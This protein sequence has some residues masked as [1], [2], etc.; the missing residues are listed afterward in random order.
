MLGLWRAEEILEMPQAELIAG[1]R[2]AGELQLPLA[3]SDSRAEGVGCICVV[4]SGSC[5]R[6]PPLWPPGRLAHLLCLPVCGLSGRHS[7][8]CFYPDTNSREALTLP[9]LCLSVTSCCQHPQQVHKG[10][11]SVFEC[12]QNQPS[13]FCP[14]H[15][16]RHLNIKF[17]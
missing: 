8:V 7:S 4:A 13:P 16:P 11:P 9:G 14:L 2:S 6:G 5:H 15:T 17:L 12:V 3:W 1:E 10:L